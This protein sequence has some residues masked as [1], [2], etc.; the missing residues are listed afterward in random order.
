MITVSHVINIT[1]Q[2]KKIMIL[3]LLNSFPNNSKDW[4]FSGGI[5]HHLSCFVDQKPTAC[6]THVHF[7]LECNN[8]YPSRISKAFA[9]D[10][11]D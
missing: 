2:Q 8:V 7:L 11:Q 6:Y 4:K 10:V 1:R 9:L 5:S 3:I